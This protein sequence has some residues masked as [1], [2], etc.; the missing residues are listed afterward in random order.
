MW[1]LKY[2]VLRIKNINVFNTQSYS[3]TTANYYNVFKFYF[4]KS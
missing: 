1:A 2:R 3:L 4:A